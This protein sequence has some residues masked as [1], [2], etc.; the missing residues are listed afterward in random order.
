MIQD[1]QRQVRELHADNRQLRG[2][3]APGAPNSA[4]SGLPQSQPTVAHDDLREWLAE[5]NLLSLVAVC[6]SLRTFRL[7]TLLR[8]TDA[9]LRRILGDEGFESADGQRLVAAIHADAA[10]T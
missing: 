10:G 9:D 4:G 6:P 2:G 1:L 7:Q 8:R 5:H 3:R